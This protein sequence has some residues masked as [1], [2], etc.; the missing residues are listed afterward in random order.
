[1]AL[2]RAVVHLVN[3]E[4]ACFAR[5]LLWVVNLNAPDEQSGVVNRLSRSLDSQLLIQH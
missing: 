2:E 3:G 1:M 5:R 4:L